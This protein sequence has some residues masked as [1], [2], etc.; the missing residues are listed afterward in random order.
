VEATTEAATDA[1]ETTTEAAS[2]AATAVTETATDAVEATTEAV[3]E[4]TTEATSE[5]SAA[6]EATSEAAT[7]G[8]AGLG[9]LLTPE[10]F[11]FEK[12]SEMIDGSDK[13]NAM[14]KGLLKKGVEA[15]QNNPDALK[16]VLEQV[17]AA[18]GM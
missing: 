18:M 15:A 7:D 5:A 6:V 16:A 10:G 3:T 17:K 4:A 13:I 2:D 1:V 14:Q 8:M 9:E 11:N 12:V